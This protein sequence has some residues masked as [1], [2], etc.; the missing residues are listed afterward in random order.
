M[1]KRNI[2]AKVCSN[3]IRKFHW[4]LFRV[5]LTFFADGVQRNGAICIR[6]II[7]LQNSQLLSTCKKSLRFFFT[8]KKKR[9]PLNFL[10]TLSRAYG[11]KVGQSGDDIYRWGREE[12]KQN[13][14]EG[15]EEWRGQEGRRMLSSS[16]DCPT[17]E[18]KLF[19]LKYGK[20]F[21]KDIKDRVAEFLWSTRAETVKLATRYKGRK[22]L[23]KRRNKAKWV[24]EEEEEVR[25][26]KWRRPSMGEGVVGEVGW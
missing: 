5:T 15:V 10:S 17:E 6:Y 19:S 26:V 23:D 22:R 24:E 13:S 21:L 14:K 7:V 9:H 11:G 4:R 8:V 1:K 25:G 2:D 16:S 12:N 20:I 3:N 18:E